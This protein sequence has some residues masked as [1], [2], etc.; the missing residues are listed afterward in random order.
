MLLKV[1]AHA[2]ARGD[3][4]ELADGV[5]RVWVR[6]P[7]VDGR[8]N[9]AMERVVAEALSLRPRQVR[10]VRGSTSRH[11]VVELDVTDLDEVRRRLG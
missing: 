9:A 4:V 6:P 1:E 11:K 7:A 5:L 10:I 8:A 3:R 2:N